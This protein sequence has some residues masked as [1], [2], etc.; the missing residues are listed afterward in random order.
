MSVVVPVAVN[1]SIYDRP[2]S[3]VSVIWFEYDA[4]VAVQDCYSCD[5]PTK[6][7]TR[8]WWPCPQLRRFS[9][10]SLAG[11]I[12][13]IWWYFLLT[14]ISDW[15]LHSSLKHFTMVIC[16]FVPLPPDNIGKGIMFAGF[17]HLSGQI[18]W[19]RYLMDILS[20]LN[21]TYRE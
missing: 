5:G 14:D 9:A 12:Q 15:E 17:V 20:N 2:N 6:V 21:E 3:I 4:S 19:P 7:P 8:R 16:V 13:I 18:L 1:S 11:S 10:A